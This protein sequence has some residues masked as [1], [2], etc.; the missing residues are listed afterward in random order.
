MHD[1]ISEMAH[2]NS[3]RLALPAT[4]SGPESGVREVA[5]AVAADIDLGVRAREEHG[6]KAREEWEMDTSPP[7][8]PIKF[9][10]HFERI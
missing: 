2:A 5:R 1:E 10:N 9:P 4:G 8:D 3:G 6:E 7:K